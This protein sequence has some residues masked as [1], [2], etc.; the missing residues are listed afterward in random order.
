MC[1]LSYFFFF[2]ETVKYRIKFTTDG[3]FDKTLC[4]PI[5]NMFLKTCIQISE[6]EVM[7]KSVSVS[8][9]YRLKLY[10]FKK[11]SPISA[12]IRYSGSCVIATGFLSCKV[13]TFHY[14]SRKLL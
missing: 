6:E 2:F 8:F 12:Q 14:S 11:L 4:R 1:I 5:T 7:D 3:L 13:E 10:F 9:N